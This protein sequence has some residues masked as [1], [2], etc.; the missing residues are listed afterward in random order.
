MFAALPMYDWEEVRP[1]TD[2]LWAHL[3]DALR[4]EGLEAPDTLDRS[5]AHDAGWARPDLLLGQ[6][7]NLPYRAAFRGKVHRLGAMDYDLPDCPPGHY[8]SVIVCRAEHA[9]LPLAGLLTRPAAYNDALS[10]SGWGGLWMLAQDMGVSPDP[11]LRTGA[12]RA[13]IE[14][15]A[16]GRADL[17]AIDAVTWRLATRF[18]APAG[19]LRVVGHT[20]ATPGMT[21]ITALPDPAPAQRVL[22]RALANLPGTVTQT[23]GLRALIPLPPAA[24]DIPLP[25]DPLQSRAK[26]RN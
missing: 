24:Y 6:I 17:A 25:P 26:S 12:H 23:L 10:Q 14:A 11:V 2:L 7:C 21:L 15:V 4:A 22:T 1:A 8:R 19:T 18:H 9:A 20:P 5:T 3:R 13:S 16:E